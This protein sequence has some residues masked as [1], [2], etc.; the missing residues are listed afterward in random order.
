M[1][2][3]LIPPEIRTARLVLRAWQSADAPALAPLLLDNVA[4]IAPWIPARVST[5]APV[6]ALEERLAGYADD[7]AADTVWRFAMFDRTDD[8]TSDTS[9]T[10]DTGAMLG[11]ISLHPRV[12]LERVPYVAADRVEMGYWLRQDRTGHGLTTEAARALIEISTTLPRFSLVEIRCDARNT[13]SAGVPARLGFTLRETLREA[14]VTPDE[15][16]IDLQVWSLPLA[17]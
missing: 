12:A 11:S 6:P 9:N 16:A 4:H 1:S 15:P 7:F 2:T 3:P 17:R 14:G 13:A 5:P 8:R 10:N